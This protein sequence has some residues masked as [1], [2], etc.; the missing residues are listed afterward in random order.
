MLWMSSGFMLHIPSRYQR[1]SSM[2]FF[3][4]KGGIPCMITLRLCISVATD[5]SEKPVMA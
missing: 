4:T 1:F 2:A 3:E 5:C